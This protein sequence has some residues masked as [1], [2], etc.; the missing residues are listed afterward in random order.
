MN[1]NNSQT[2]KNLWSELELE[3][4]VSGEVPQPL[5]VESPWYVRLLIGFSG[6]L[7]AIFLLGFLAVGF[8]FIYRHAA[9][10][11]ILGGLMLVLAYMMLLKK[12]E[13]DF[14]NQFALAVS[15]AGQFLIMF[16]LFSDGQLFTKSISWISLA[17]IQVALAVVM[18]NSVHRVWSAFAAAIALS[19][20]FIIWQ[21]NY[22]QTALIMLA[23]ALIWL[24]EF[25]WIEY[26]EKLK[27]IGYGLTLALIYLTSM[28]FYHFRVF[29]M[30]SLFKENMIQPWLGEILMGL[31]LLYVV[32]QLLQRQRIRIPGKMSGLSLIATVCLVV[33][34]LKAYGLIVGIF[35]ILLG[36][37]NAN[38]ILTALG[39]ISLMYYISTY[40]YLLQYTLLEK[41]QLLAVLGISLLLAYA[42]LRFGI[43]NI[44]KEATDEK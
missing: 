41:S 7:A 39:I 34:S 3:G 32:W 28:G 29:R 10:A 19:F 13:N 36:Y 18:P 43:F 37:A 24:N 12:S 16:G 14:T 9:A 20:T 8:E 11:I 35:I 30:S 38:R 31:V 27:P 15:F 6:W 26:Q 40:Y 23:V 4:L 22:I 17:A 5:E 42:F 25:K 2:R 21:I 33:L 1:T 44:N